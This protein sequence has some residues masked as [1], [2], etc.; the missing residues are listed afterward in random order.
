M[1]SQPVVGETVLMDLATEA[2]YR[3]DGVGAR[4]WELIGEA[5]QL[6]D[7]IGALLSEFEVEEA[8]LLADLEALLGDAARRG[9]VELTPSG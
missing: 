2:F 4:L 3:L 1:L 8:I 7:I 5:D 6:S 9:L